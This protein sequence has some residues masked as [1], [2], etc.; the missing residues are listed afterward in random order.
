VYIVNLYSAIE[1]KLSQDPDLI[2]GREIDIKFH[3]RTKYDL[4][5]AEITTDY[6]DIIKEL[7]DIAQDRE[8][9]KQAREIL[10]KKIKDILD[11]DA[12]SKKAQ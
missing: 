11:K 6:I 5:V 8:L 2:L 3:H 1:K 4:K 10:S 7:R 9:P 12:K